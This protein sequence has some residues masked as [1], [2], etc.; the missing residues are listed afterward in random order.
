[1]YTYWGSHITAAVSTELCAVLYVQYVC[2]MYCAAGEHHHE[3]MPIPQAPTLVPVK[4]DCSFGHFVAPVRAV[5]VCVL[6]WQWH[7][8]LGWQCAGVTAHCI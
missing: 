5:D 3:P 2:S 6:R 7:V 1:M 8:A 4:S